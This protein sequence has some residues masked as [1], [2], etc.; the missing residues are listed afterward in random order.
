MTTYSASTIKRDIEE[1]LREASLTWEEFIER[2]EA[3]EL[4]DISDALDFAYRALVRPERRGQAERG[5]H[6]PSP[7]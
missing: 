7:G 5:R 1:L 3:D 6:A 4:L 2:G